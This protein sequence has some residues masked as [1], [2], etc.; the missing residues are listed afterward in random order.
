MPSTG[1]C[2]GIQK[3]CKRRV[4]PKKNFCTKVTARSS[5]IM[6][7]FPCAA[8]VLGSPNARGSP[9]STSTCL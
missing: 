7:W 2:S 5:L 4:L 8:A 6:G 1:L 3:K 9:H